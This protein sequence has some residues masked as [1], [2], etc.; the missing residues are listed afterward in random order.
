MV[1]DE[2]DERVVPKGR[3]A[4]TLRKAADAVVQVGHGVGTLVI[5]DAVVGH[6]PRLM[7]GQREKAHMPGARVGAAGEHV[8]QAVE[9][10]AVGNAPTMGAALLGRKLCVAMRALVAGGKEIALHVG[11]VDVATIEKLRGISRTAKRAGDGGQRARL[12]RQ[13][14]DAR[15]R[16]RG[17]AAQRANGAAVGA[18]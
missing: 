4:Q 17:I 3:A 8:E 2:H 1:G 7:A 12:A 13:L 18:E 16:E 5:G 15:R 14:H 9:G 11:E 6:F 10:D